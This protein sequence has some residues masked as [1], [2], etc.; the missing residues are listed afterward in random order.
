MGTFGLLTE[1]S[2][3]N[4]QD[5]EPRAYSNIPVALNFILAG[6]VYSAGGVV[7]DPAVPLENANFKVHG[8]VL[9][10]ARSIKIGRMSGKIDMVVPYVWLSGTA[11]FNGQPVSRDVSGLGDPRFRMS[12]NFIGSPALPLSGFK[13]Y[14]QKLIVG[15]SLQI[16]VPVSQY[17]PDRLVN[18][19][20]N[21]FTFKP[22]LGLSRT[23]G[24]LYLEL[25]GGM[26]FYTVNHDFYQGKTRSQEPIGSVQG[27]FIYTFKRGIWTS[28][29]GTYYWGGSTTVNGVK[30]DDLQKNTRL[31]LTF[32][33]PVNLHNSLK[34]YYSTGVSTRTGTDFN[35]VGL[36]WQYRWGG[37]LPKAKQ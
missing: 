8:S 36:A 29:D 32:A 16:R 22:E 33:L 12:L 21:R 2:P 7:F 19:G 35:V 1:L 13:D 34:F 26:A 30:G 3:L 37:G 10:Y 28:L 11:D 20:T 4:S 25:S 31:G 27:H 17:D 5:L 15:A 18:I 14:K 23:V 9:A 24:R 6:Y